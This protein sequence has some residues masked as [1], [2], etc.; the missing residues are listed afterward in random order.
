MR[1]L[2]AVLA[3]VIAVAASSGEVEALREQNAMLTRQVEA[4][5]DRLTRLGQRL[6][7]LEELVSSKLSNDEQQSDEVAELSVPNGRRLTSSTSRASLTY[8]GESV[9]IDTNLAVKGSINVTGLVEKQVVAFCAYSGTN[10]SFTASNN[11]IQTLPFENVRFNYGGAYNYSSDSSFTAPVSGLY[12]FFARF[13]TSNVG[14]T[15]ETAFDINNGG[16]FVT[17]YSMASTNYYDSSMSQLIDL[18]AGDVGAS[19]RASARG[20]RA[21]VLRAFVADQR[22]PRDAQSNS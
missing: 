14:W 8:D 11:L 18:V 15:I 2:C 1:R 21:R 7:R 20:G 3:G 22:R 17:G 5:N 19:A 9:T 13:S 6:M 16:A 4:Q 10:P 12:M